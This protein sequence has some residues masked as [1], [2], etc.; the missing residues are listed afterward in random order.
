M[1]MTIT[2]CGCGCLGK[3]Q[4]PQNLENYRQ[5]LKQELASVEDRIRTKPD[6]D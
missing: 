6:K 2:D 3:G 1:G 4:T 5:Y